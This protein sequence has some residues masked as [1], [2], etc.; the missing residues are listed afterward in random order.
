MTEDIPE[1]TYK[2]Q[3][4]LSYLDVD[5]NNLALL[6]DAA[7]EA[8][9][10][11]RVDI[12]QDLLG[13]Y[14]NLEPLPGKELNMYG[15]A[16]MKSAQ[17]AKAIDVFEA[18]LEDNPTDAALRFNLAWS[19]AML[20]NYEKALE[21]LDTQ[22]INALPEAAMLD[23]QIKHQL[24]KLQMASQA[25]KHHMQVHKGHDGLMAA[26]SVLAM[27]I[28]DIELARQTAEQSGEHPDG[29]TTLGMLALGD[30]DPHKASNFFDKALDINAHGPRSWIGKGLSEL[31]IGDM[32]S[33]TLK[34]DHGAKMFGTHIGSWIAAGWAFF[35]LGDVQTAKERFETAMNLDHNFAES[36]GALAVIDVLDGNLEKARKAVR[37][38]IGLD[39]NCFSAILA[40][41]LII[42][43]QGKPDVAKAILDRGLNTP[44]DDSGRNLAQSMVKMGLS[45]PSV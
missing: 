25:A 44:I 13:R 29:L 31:L 39:K 12:T 5:P 22:T 16:H 38:A 35:I 2:L 41:S 40:Q 8:L 21:R 20:K 34:I 33:G 24:G 6:S 7:G 37:T 19:E 4:L 42:S 23:V 43:S 28:E 3:N 15:L 18:L 17:Y 45:S 9:L 10:S 26:I 32:K 27:D 36:H 11:G 1:E 14:A 30:D